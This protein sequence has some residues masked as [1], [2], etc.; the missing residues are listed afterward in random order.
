MNELMDEMKVALK[1]PFPRKSSFHVEADGVVS[2]YIF[3]FE[4]K[5][6]DITIRSYHPIDTKI[7][8]MDVSLF[9]REGEVI[10]T[11]KYFVEY[12][13]D[14]LSYSLNWESVEPVE[15][16]ARFKIK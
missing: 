2:Y 9:D 15:F 4:K 10:V 11:Y 13:K 14:N 5:D 16:S 12:V 1:K 3:A 6:N 8:R 7:K